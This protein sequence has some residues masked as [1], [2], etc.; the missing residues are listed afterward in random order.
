MY[1]V[2]LLSSV[3]QEGKDTLL[4]NAV[5]WETENLVRCCLQANASPSASPGADTRGDGGR[6]VLIQAAH[7]GN[8]RILKQLLDAG[9]DHS[10][11][12]SIGYTA[13]N[14][15]A[16]E[17]HLECIQLLLAAGADANKCNQTGTSPIMTTVFENH[18]E[19]LR[20]LLPVSDLSLTTRQGLRVIHICVMHGSEECFELLLPHVS[21]VD[22]RTLFGVNA[23]GQVSPSYNATPLHLAC[24]RG[25]QQMAKA[26]LK[27][28]ANRMVR[29]SLQRTPLFTASL[30]GHL[31]CVVLLVGQPG[32]SKMTPDEV[33]TVTEKGFMA[34]HVAAQNGH[35]KICGVLLEA[36]AR[37]DA[38][39]YQGATPFLLA[40]QKHPTNAPLL[41]LLSGGSPAQ[42][43]PGTVCDHCGKTAAQASVPFLKTCGS[44]HGMRYCGAVCSAA[45]WPG[46]KAACRARAAERE[47]KTKPNTF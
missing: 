33:N 18:G 20:A 1:T 47:S 40:Q 8:T 34:L 22:V 42:P 26:L 37:L 35:V 11:T 16:Q 43:L 41:A 2:E 32:R 44:C 5:H 39:T 36:G 30:G 12:D 24:E 19:C 6:L 21:D 45:A 31:S 9:A 10:L 28:G 13:L 3:S 38:E 46:H 23:N 15:A 29:E 27:R 7:Q 17:G 4:L 25:R 14:A